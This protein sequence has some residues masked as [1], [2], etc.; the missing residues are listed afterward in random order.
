MPDESQWFDRRNVLKTTAAGVVGAAGVATATTPV[1]AASEGDTF[2]KN[3]TASFDPTTSTSDGYTIKLG[4][5]LEVLEVGSANDSNDEGVHQFRLTSDVVV[6]DEN[7]QMPVTVSEGYGDSCSERLDDHPANLKEQKLR[8][9]VPDVEEDETAI[10]VDTTAEDELHMA[11]GRC[12]QD[13]SAYD[14]GTTD[15]IKAAASAVGLLSNALYLS[16]PQAVALDL[17]LT[18]L[19]SDS[20]DVNRSDLFEVSEYWSTGFFRGGGTVR[21]NVS[22][23]YNRTGEVRAEAFAGNNY[24]YPSTGFDIRCGD[25]SVSVS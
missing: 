15:S 7:D 5:G 18:F 13:N 21:F 20:P 10:S 23:D 3:T 6:V 2:E 24:D 8:L 19:G 14:Y 12:G 22:I 9:E 1:S 11:P 4:V 25:S 17:V 16:A